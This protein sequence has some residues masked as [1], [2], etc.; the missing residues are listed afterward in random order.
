M[1]PPQAEAPIEVGRPR[2]TAKSG[3]T[4][5]PPQAESSDDA[6]Q[7]KKQHNGVERS[8]LLLVLLITQ[9]PIS[10]FI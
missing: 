8:V 9:Y 6:L 5:D 10:G 7:K 1:N 2:P 4:A 3:K